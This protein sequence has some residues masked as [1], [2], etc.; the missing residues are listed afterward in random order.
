MNIRVEN[1]TNIAIGNLRG[2]QQAKYV[3][4][5]MQNISIQGCE[6]PIHNSA[7]T[8]IRLISNVGLVIK[9]FLLMEFLLSSTHSLSDG[10]A[11][12]IIKYYIN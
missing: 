1:F 11:L 9:E 8:K 7:A 12:L 6:I 5:R 2:T 3:F 10:F 4:S